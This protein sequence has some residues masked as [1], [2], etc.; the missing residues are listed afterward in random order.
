MLFIMHFVCSTLHLDIVLSEKQLR[1]SFF[2]KKL[3]AFS[4]STTLAKRSVSDAWL[5]SECF[6]LFIGLLR[7]YSGYSTY[8]LVFSP[9]MGIHFSDFTSV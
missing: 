6:S 2:L 9:C 7:G 8:I 4:R 5:I 1:W 3:T